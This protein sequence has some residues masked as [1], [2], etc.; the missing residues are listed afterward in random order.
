MT[1]NFK[2]KIIYNYKYPSQKW[3]VREKNIKELPFEVYDKESGDRKKAKEFFGLVSVNKL[4][5]FF[6]GNFISYLSEEY[7][8]NLTEDYTNFIGGSGSSELSTDRI[9]KMNI[10]E[11][12]ILGWFLK[13]NNIK[14]N[15]KKD[16]FIE[17]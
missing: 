13:R 15:K 11:Y 10:R 12:M 9:R 16:T 1:G 8:D 6:V 3:Y 17:K 4:E 2:F 5:S 14:Y 7:I